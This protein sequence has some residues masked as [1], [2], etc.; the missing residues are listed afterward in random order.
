MAVV[1]KIKSLT[2]NVVDAQAAQAAKATVQQIWWAGLGAFARAQ[3]SGAGL[4]AKAQE[5]GNKVFEELVKEGEAIQSKTQK[6][7]EGT[8]S[9]GSGKA[10]EAWGKV[11]QVFTDRVAKALTLLGVPSRKEITELSDRVAQLATL[12]KELNEAAGKVEKAEAKPAA[13][14]ATK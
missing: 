6:A 12:V 8:V 5:S 10:N 3:E 7:L 2:S 11:E 13:A 4:V 1:E 9:V 14:K